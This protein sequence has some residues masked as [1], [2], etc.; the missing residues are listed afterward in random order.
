M[1]IHFSV[2]GEVFNQ[3]LITQMYFEGDPLIHLCSMI[4]SIPDLNARK[5]LIGKLD[6]SK[7]QE[8]KMLTYKFDIILRGK[9]QTIFE[10]LPHGP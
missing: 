7:S 3:R 9:N 1:H 8:N 5:S 4:N 10:N 6:L 2:F